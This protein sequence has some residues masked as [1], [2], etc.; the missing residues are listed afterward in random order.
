MDEIDEK[1]PKFR[2]LF[3]LVIAHCAV[4]YWYIKDLGGK[5]WR[6]YLTYKESVLCAPV[7]ILSCYRA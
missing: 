4:S 6:V 3:Y 7:Y 1:E 5:M 2:L